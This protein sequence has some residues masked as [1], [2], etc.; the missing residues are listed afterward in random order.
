MNYKVSVIA[1]FDHILNWAEISSIIGQ[2]HHVFEDKV[3]VKVDGPIGGD[4][5]TYKLYFE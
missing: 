4:E 5:Y 2:P 1:I 3:C